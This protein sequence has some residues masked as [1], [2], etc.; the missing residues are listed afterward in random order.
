MRRLL[1]RAR[2]R[3]PGAW[4]HA[5]FLFTYWAALMAAVGRLRIDHLLAAAAA[6]CLGFA[7]AATARFLRAFFGYALVGLSYDASRFIERLGLSPDRVLLCNLR[8]A[9]LAVF[10]VPVSGR[11]ETLQ[12]LFLRHH[13]PAA[14]LFF[15]LPYGLYLLIAALFAVWLFRR[16]EHAAAR[17]CWAFLF[18]NLMGFATYHI[19]PAAPPW[20][21]HAHGCAVDLAAPTSEGPALAR[22]DAMLGVRFF[23]GLY[24]RA[25]EV[26]GAIPSLH[27][28]YPLL[29]AIEGYRWMGRAGRALAIVYIA[30]M[31][32]AAVYLDHHW[33]IDL[34]AGW[35]TCAVA[36]FL[37]RRWIPA[38]ARPRSLAQGAGARGV[39]KRDAAS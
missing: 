17:Y 6:H 18:M 37:V 15:S 23:Y 34:A 30:W 31:A 26:F 38:H 12:D 39:P 8:R 4:I 5:P 25:S 29:L 33:I 14:D 20:Y 19:L 13:S 21:F 35:L 36:T 1:V 9:E 16:D 2:C 11:T 7:S 28:A 3:W 24:G 10:G 27:A 22:V 32:A